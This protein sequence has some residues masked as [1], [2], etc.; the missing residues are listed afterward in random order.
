LWPAWWVSFT[1]WN[2]LQPFSDHVTETA[3]AFANLPGSLA[4]CLRH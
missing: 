2:V 4:G 3:P 1:L